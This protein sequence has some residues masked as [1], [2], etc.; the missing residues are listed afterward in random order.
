MKSHLSNA[1]QESLLVAL[2]CSEAPEGRDEWTM[3]LLANKLVEL[4]IVSE[5]FLSNLAINQFKQPVTVLRLSDKLLKIE[6]I[7]E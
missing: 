5:H 2:A 1:K 7:G 4:K 3:Q 6:F